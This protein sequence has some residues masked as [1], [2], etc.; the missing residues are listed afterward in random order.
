LGQLEGLFETADQTSPI[1]RYLLSHRVAREGRM[2]KAEVAFVA[3][4]VPSERIETGQP[5]S[6]RLR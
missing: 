5:T 4:H 3:H 1:D 6:R 2:P